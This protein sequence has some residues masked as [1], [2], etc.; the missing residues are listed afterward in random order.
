[1]DINVNSSNACN[2]KLV[3]G[4]YRKQERFHMPRVEHVRFDP[5]FYDA[6]SG[7]FKPPQDP[8]ERSH[9]LGRL[10]LATLIKGGTPYTPCA[11]QSRHEA[12][13]YRP[14]WVS[15]IHSI[16]EYDDLRPLDLHVTDVRLIDDNDD[17]NFLFVSRTMSAD[18][19]W[20]AKLSTAELESTF[21]LELSADMDQTQKSI[22]EAAQNFYDRAA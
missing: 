10:A 2:G 15:S 12:V 11:S 16:I 18:E 3:A 5:L 8:E 17:E 22:A 19:Q 1:M 6:L 20:I 21:R 13:S 14:S 7:E 9:T 4:T